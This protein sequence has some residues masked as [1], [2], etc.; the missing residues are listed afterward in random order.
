MNQQS[1]F[2]SLELAKTRQNLLKALSI[3]EAQ[4]QAA[5]AMCAL[6]CAYTFQLGMG[7]DADAGLREVFESAKE[8]ANASK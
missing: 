8:R 1:Q 3:V 6:A 7:M 5:D 2:L 4:Q